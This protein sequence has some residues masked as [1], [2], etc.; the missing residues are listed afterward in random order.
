MIKR[1]IALMLTVLILLPVGALSAE[2]FDFSSIIQYEYGDMFDV[3]LYDAAGGE[4][5]LPDVPTL[6][7]YASDGCGA[8]LTLISQMHALFEVFGTAYV[9]PLIL[10]QDDIPADYIELRQLPMAQNLSLAGANILGSLPTIYIVDAEGMV[11]YRDNDMDRAV[12]KFLSM[13]Y[14]PDG[15]LKERADQYL[16]SRMDTPEG[17]TPLLYFSMTGCPDCM[18]ADQAMQD[19]PRISELFAIERLYRYNETDH[20][21]WRDDFKLMASVYGV[22]WYPSF[23]VFDEDASVLVGEVPTDTLCDALIAAVER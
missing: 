7:V 14:F 1:W 8:C 18:R 21:K 22:T 5:A 2:G 6:I 23:L 11:L 13:G 12:E 3:P 17:I 10:W 9:K 15:Y 20:E 16:L 19:D 4:I